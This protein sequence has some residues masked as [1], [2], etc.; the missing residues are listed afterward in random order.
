MTMMTTPPTTDSTSMWLR[1]TWPMAEAAAPSATN[2]VEKPSTKATE[3]PSTVRLAT[4]VS[5]VAGELVEADAGHVA[6]VGRHQRQHAG[7][8]ERDKPGDGSA[9]KGDR[10]GHAGGTRTL[11]GCG[12]GL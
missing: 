9:G 1:T 7:R 3:A 5:P 6:E 10:D 4:R 12:R 11:F 2:T 8:E